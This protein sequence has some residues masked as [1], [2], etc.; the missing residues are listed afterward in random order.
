VSAETVFVRLYGASDNAFWLDSSRVVE[1]LSRFSFMGDATHSAAQRIDY[2]CAARE[3]AV[4]QG[5]RCEVLRDTDLF[6][7]LRQR[8]AASAMAPDAALPFDFCGGFVGYLGYEL[9]QLCGGDPGH[10]AEL[11][12][13]SLLYV[14]RFLAF[15]HRAGAV[16][17]VARPDAEG[18][19][20]ALDW[21]GEVGRRIA[22]IDREDDADLC[23]HRAQPPV[24]TPERDRDAYIDAVLACQ[25]HIRAGDTY[26]VCLTN[27]LRAHARADALA[28]YRTLRR[29]NP[30]PHAAYLRLPH[31]AV[32]CSSPER[33]LKI[34]RD[35]VAE[36]RPIKGTAARGADPA[37]DAAA[38]QA[39]RASEKDRAEHL[40]IVDLLRNDLGR[41]CATGS[42]RV[43][44]LMAVESYATVHQMVSTIQGT[45]RPDRDAI[46][47]IR[48][49]FPGGSMTG[50]PKLRTM[51]IIDGLETSA[52]GV[53][54]GAIGYLSLDGTADLNIVIRSIVVTG[55]QLEIG[56]GGA[57]VAMSD[58]AAEH[59]EALLKADV[60]LRAVGLHLCGRAGEP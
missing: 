33:F 16:Y 17:A 45:L 9:K 27:R 53:Y 31:A 42:V 37:S 51:R 57:V 8:L 55:T 18:A 39:L 19:A 21:V 1:G 44:R 7:Y 29:C 11:P 12:D 49:A 2:R 52:R 3:L 14:E 28:L 59:A 36:A 15:D 20:T 13:A 5:H 23:L 54:S 6:E 50:A 47:A 10:R 32:A 56:A 43:P 24:F 48:S 41:V 22:A 25:R 46:D 30:A 34:G 4:H 38:A 40:M 58:P 26:E 35:R 60:L